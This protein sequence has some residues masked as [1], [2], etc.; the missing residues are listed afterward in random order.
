MPRSPFPFFLLVVICLAACEP[1]RAPPPDEERS[2][3]SSLQSQLP[4]A[5]RDLDDVLT[6]TAEQRFMTARRRLAQDFADLCGDSFCGGRYSNIESVSFRCAFAVATGRVRRCTWIFGASSEIV[7]GNTGV[8]H[9]DARTFTCGIAIDALPGELTDMVLAA[10]ADG[11]VR[12]PLPG[13]AKASL[14]DALVP[15]LGA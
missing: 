8:I 15:C 14:F 2:G 4:P 3:E 7:S 6:G 12:R 10:G 9:V 1:S 5:Y 13:R 11:P